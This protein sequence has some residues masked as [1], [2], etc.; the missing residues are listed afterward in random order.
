MYIECACMEYTCCKCILLSEFPML[1]AFLPREPRGSIWVN[2]MA[3]LAPTP[4]CPLLSASAFLDA[5]GTGAG[6]VIHWYGWGNGCVRR[7]WHGQVRYRRHQLCCEGQRGVLQEARWGPLRVHVCMWLWVDTLWK[8]LAL[9]WAWC[10]VHRHR[11]RYTY[12]HRQIKTRGTFCFF[13]WH[14]LFC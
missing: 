6:A 14:G 13:T 12:T 4:S 11:Q 7:N 8:L 5:S 1:S 10:N 9:R 2:Q 3:T